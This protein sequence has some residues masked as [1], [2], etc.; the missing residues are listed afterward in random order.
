MLS[1]GQRRDTGG[2]IQRL[3]DQL[4]LKKLEKASEKRQP[5]ARISKDDEIAKCC[6]GKAGNLKTS[7]NAWAWPLCKWKAECGGPGF[8]VELENILA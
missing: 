3:K 1:Q 2:G 7:V 5:M 4:D 6:K 8:G